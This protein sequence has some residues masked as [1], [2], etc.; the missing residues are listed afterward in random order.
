MTNTGEQSVVEDVDGAKARR[1]AYESNIS[2]EVY[3]HRPADR[4]KAR[5]RIK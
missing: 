2:T 3:E 5:V 1:M 4:G